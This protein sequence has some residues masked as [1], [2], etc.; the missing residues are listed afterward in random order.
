MKKAL[1]NQ[2]KEIYY[3]NNNKKVIIDRNDKTTY[4]SRL[5]GEINS[6]L[7]GEINSGLWGDISGLWGE[8]NSE[9]RGDISGLWGEITKIIGNIDDCQLTD[10]DRKKGIDITQ[11]IKK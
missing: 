11:L 6:G 1:T 2:I 9:L 4:L 8:I 7:R 10:E 3:Y 5:W